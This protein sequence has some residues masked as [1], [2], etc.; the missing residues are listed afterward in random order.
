LNLRA[1]EKIRVYFPNLNG[2]RSIAAL[3]V[4]F[5]HIEQFKS[6]FGLDSYWD[7]SK[8]IS[9]IGSLG[10]TLFF[11]LSGFLITYLLLI[12]EKN[13]A[14]INIKDFYI[15][16]ILRIWPLYFLI[17]L[18]ALFVFPRFEFFRIPGIDISTVYSNFGI[19]L[20][21][22]LTFFA[23]LALTSYGVIP[24]VSQT[25]SIGTEEQ[26]YL[27]WP[28]LLKFLKKNRIILMV[29]IVVLYL[30]IKAALFRYDQ[31]R[32]IYNFW[33]VFKI[34]IMATG[35]LFA[36]L[37]FYRYKFL[38]VLTNK[39]LFYCVLIFTILLISLGYH[40]PYFHDEVYALLFGILILNFACTEGIG[41]SL[42]FEPFKYLG[43]I[44][45]GLYMY[46]PIAILFTLKIGLIL[47]LT[48]NFIMYPLAI[49]F[50][51]GIS[52]LSYEFFE[53]RFLLMKLRFSKL[54][55]GDAKN[56]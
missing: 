28:V 26:F 11:V 7:K 35:G 37:S 23:N 29:S 47:N 41:L 21:L 40:F 54:V 45:Y 52:S 13:T 10:V 6:L 39:I 44:S 17:V 53:S 49:L 56:G 36:L 48:S 8:F 42:E 15:R 4:I 12:E 55:S 18:L 51:V 9:V 32:M 22:Y 20:I 38:S 24:F 34:D 27:I 30:I 1:S 33:S 43:K 31:S 46:H 5:H 3:L 2:I 25:W 14:T 16:R 50:A 19:K